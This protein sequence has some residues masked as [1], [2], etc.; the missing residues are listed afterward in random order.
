MCQWK[1][2]ENRS[3]FSEDMERVWCAIFFETRCIFAWLLSLWQHNVI[4][5][6]TKPKHQKQCYI[7][8]H[9]YLTPT[10]ILNLTI[11][12]ESQW[13]IDY[14]DILSI[15]KYSQLFTRVKYISGERY[16]ILPIQ[17]N[18]TECARTHRQTE[19]Q[20]WKQ[21][22]CQFHSVHLA[23]TKRHFLVTNKEHS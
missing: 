20:K 2:Y 23:D 4:A 14:N 15:W 6:V 7:F 17:T 5:A 13:N 18:G 3:I 9:F 12:S 22:I 1:N 8:V 19:T 16:V 10:S 11:P 21:Y